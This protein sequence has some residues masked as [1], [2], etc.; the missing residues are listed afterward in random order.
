VR[1]IKGIVV[2]GTHSGVGKTTVALGF[3]AALRRRGLTVA[4]FKVGP[5]FIDPGHHAQVTGRLGRNL[6]GWMLSRAANR[7]VF[8]RHATGADV[9][10]VEGVMGLF[11]GYGGRDEAGSTAQMAKWMGLPV[12]LVV[13]AAGM[14]RSAAALIQGF[15]RFDPALTFA[16][17]LFNRLGS[18]G[19]LDYLKEAIAAYAATPLLGGLPRDEALAMPERHLG[20]MTAGEHALSEAACHRLADDIES[21][22]DL[23][24]LL[25][26]LPDIVPTDAEPLGCSKSCSEGVRIGVARDDAFCFYYPDNLDLLAE[27]GAELV[28]F[29]PLADN[30]LPERLYGLYIG[31][32]YPELH[33][34]ELAANDTMRRD[35]LEASREGMPVY[36][37]CG[38]FM[39]LCRQLEDLA[40]TVHAMCGCFPFRTRMHGR[41]KSLGYREVRM[42][43]PTLLG[44]KDDVARGHEFH[45]SDIVDMHQGSPVATAYQVSGRSGGVTTEGYQVDRTL[46]SY[47]HLHFVSRPEC[48]AALVSTSRAYRQATR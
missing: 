31:G 18:R 15:E 4:P 22:L 10:V 28:P 24:R 3:M 46:G 11:D 39:Y 9:A 47:I 42:T 40:G 2:A 30:R 25:A 41:L 20:L 38:G 45:Y 13:S 23:D 19:H 16:G 17:V 34:A 1:A 14:A 35:I 8:T 43:V 26:D 48:A 21:G 27:A 5:D 37:E 29:S 7:A 36:A 6:D 32:G 12:L 44:G 33:A